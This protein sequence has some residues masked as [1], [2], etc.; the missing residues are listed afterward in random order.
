MNCKKRKRITGAAGRILLAW[1]LVIS[2]CAWTQDAGAASHTGKAIHQSSS[3]GG[4]HEGIK[5]HGHWTIEIRNPNGSLVTHREFENSIAGG[6]GGGSAALSAFLG[7]Q[8]LVGAW[9]VSLG[10]PGICGISGAP[11]GGNCNI[12]EPSGFSIGFANSSNLTI[13]VNASTVALSGSVTTST[14][15]QITSVATAV[16]GCSPAIAA[17][18]PNCSVISGWTGFSVT[19]TALAT[20]VQVSPGQIIQVKVVLS[21]S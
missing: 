9:A 3:K 7:R 18:G 6:S 8:Y 21:F 17:Y 1:I 4:P 13:A 5:V 12:F 19:G 16:L 10:G 15:G 2:Q 20:A 11:A 14:A